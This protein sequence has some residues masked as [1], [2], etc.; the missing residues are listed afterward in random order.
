MLFF[1]LRRHPTRLRRVY[2]ILF[3]CRASFLL[4]AEKDS[5]CWETE[6]RRKN[7]RRLVGCCR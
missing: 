4:L 5:G 1:L 6:R 2:A 7:P 3:L